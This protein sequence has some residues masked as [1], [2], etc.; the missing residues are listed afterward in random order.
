LPELL[1]KL[2]LELLPQLLQLSGELL[3]ACHLL[4]TADLLLRTGYHLQL[5]ASD[6]LRAGHQLRADANLQLCSYLQLPDVLVVLLPTVLQLLVLLLLAFFLELP[7]LL[8]QLQVQEVSCSTTIEKRQPRE[9]PT[10]IRSR[11]F[12]F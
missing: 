3:R 1:L 2:L 7:P 11:S 9:G 6:G 10:A 8:V 5:H 12:P 4:C